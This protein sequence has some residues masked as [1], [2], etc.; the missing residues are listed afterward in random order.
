MT[1][2][3]QSLIG[4]GFVEAKGQEFRVNKL[5]TMNDIHT[6]ALR[7]QEKMEEYGVSMYKTTDG[8]CGSVYNKGGKRSIYE[9]EPPREFRG[10]IESGVFVHCHPI[11]QSER[12]AEGRS[13]HVLPSGTKA[14]AGD[15]EANN[16]SRVI[17]GYLNVA[18]EYGLTMFIGIEGIS[19]EDYVTRQLRRKVGSHD[20]AKQRV[21]KVL[22]GNQSGTAFVGDEFR[23][24]VDKKFSMDEDLILLSNTQDLGTRYFLHLSWEKLGELEPVYG[25]LENLCFGDGL[26]S[27]IGHLGVKVPHK[28]NLGDAA[29][30]LY[31]MPQKVK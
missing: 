17:G 8:K 13:L 24:A 31:R 28:D 20:L 19:R 29:S 1:D 18:S 2:N 4:I 12:V 30:V 9:P 3:E 21:W 15:F 5:P 27:L 25:S 6:L 11:P 7:T 23:E 22:S 14:F 16:W 10:K 26:K